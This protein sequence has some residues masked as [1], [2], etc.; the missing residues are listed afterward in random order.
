M[1][2]ED[3]V[4]DRWYK[5]KEVD[6]IAGSKGPSVYKRR[7]LEHYALFVIVKGTAILSA[8]TKLH[9]FSPDSVVFGR[10]GQFVWIES[11]LPPEGRIYALY[12]DLEEVPDRSFPLAGQLQVALGEEDAALCAELAGHWRSANGLMRMRSQAAFYELLCAIVRSASLENAE[13]LKGDLARIKQYMEQH[14]REEITIEQLA[15][16]MNVSARHFRRLFKDAYKISANEY[17]TQLRISRAKQLFSGTEEQFSDIACQVGYPNETHFR[18]MFKQ[19]VGMPPALYT[20]NRKIKVGAFSW[21]NIGQLL[22]LKIVP[23]AAPVDHYWTDHYKRKLSGDLMA[24]LVHDYAFN[25]ELLQKL[26]PDYIVGID[27]YL[28]EEEKLGLGEVAPA[29]FVPFEQGDWRFH[30]QLVGR[31]LNR[32]AEAERWIGE[33]ERQ[34]ASVAQRLG[35]LDEP[36]R[37]LILMIC[38]DSLYFWNGHGDSDYRELFAPRRFTG[39]M[40]K[41]FSRLSLE[42]AADLSPR[43][44]LVLLSEDTGS[45]RHWKL[46]QAGK[47][48]NELIA[49]KEKKVRCLTMGPPFDYTAYNHGLI[50]EQLVRLFEQQ[51]L[52]I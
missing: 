2:N 11:E 15:D 31:F 52:V 4:F 30:L 35:R 43:Q 7:K 23:H 45:M 40:D 47:S 14:Y 18:R 21:P 20:R 29:F 6:E 44:I 19:Q 24:E 46:L 39:T 27:S 9:V 51:S 26:R 22:P 10:P 50:L 16:E 41:G 3:A 42:E 5:L 38:H 28:T 36:E 34:A 37:L 17:L 13:G 32:T 8:D 12:F 48:W 1:T 49:V 25:R 33:Y